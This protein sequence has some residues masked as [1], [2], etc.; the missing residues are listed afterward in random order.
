LDGMTYYYAQSGAGYISAYFNQASV[1]LF[2]YVPHVLF[3]I[4]L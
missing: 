4:I 2:K 1:I 3:S